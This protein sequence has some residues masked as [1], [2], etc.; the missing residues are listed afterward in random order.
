MLQ[1]HR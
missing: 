1:R